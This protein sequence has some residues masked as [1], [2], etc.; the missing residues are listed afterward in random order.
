[1]GDPAGLA[2]KLPL[3]RDR[4]TKLCASPGGYREISVQQANKV[5]EQ[6]NNIEWRASRVGSLICPSSPGRGRCRTSCPYLAVSMSSFIISA[7]VRPCTTASP[8]IPPR[9]SSYSPDKYAPLSYHQKRQGTDRTLSEGRDNESLCS[10]GGSLLLTITTLSGQCSSVETPEQHFPA[11]IHVSMPSNFAGILGIPTTP[12]TPAKVTKQ[13][14][15]FIQRYKS[16][17]YRRLMLC[18]RWPCLR[19]HLKP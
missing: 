1:M 8:C 6:S 15:I 11:K 4:W 14:L 18:T 19:R 10:L 17:S 16:R 7:V 12:D 13:S 9:L 5:V 2:D 3:A